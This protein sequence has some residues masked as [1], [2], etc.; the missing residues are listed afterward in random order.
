MGIASIKQLRGEILLR[1]PVEIEVLRQLLEQLLFEH[2]EIMPLKIVLLAVE[3]IKAPRLLLRQI[4]FQL[5]Q[6]RRSVFRFFRHMLPLNFN[7]A[8][9]IRAEHLR[10]GGLNTRQRCR[11]RVP[12]AVLTGADDHQL[13]RNGLQQRLS[14]G[15]A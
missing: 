4:L 11:R 1:Q 14:R 13:R 6:T 9:F 8:A 10:T 2:A 5:F 3:N 12:V 15:I 7:V